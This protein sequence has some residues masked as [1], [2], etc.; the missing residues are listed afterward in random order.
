MVWEAFIE[1]WGYEHG[2]ADRSTCSYWRQWQ[3][4]AYWF[5][6]PR[7][8][9]H[10]HRHSALHFL[11]PSFVTVMSFPIPETKGVKKND[12]SFKIITHSNVHTSDINQSKFKHAFKTEQCFS[13]FLKNK[14]KKSITKNTGQNWDEDTGNGFFFL[15]LHF[16]IMLW[17]YV[18]GGWPESSLQTG[19][20]SHRRNS[21]FCLSSAS[22]L[23]AQL[24]AGH[25]TSG[26]SQRILPADTQLIL[27]EGN[28]PCLGF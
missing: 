13:F 17:I 6:G 8:N 23:P 20:W 26:G 14:E 22:R 7:P 1:K 21:E 28:H 18:Q 2:T 16:G 24:P 25:P 27:T 12:Q 19:L 15:K 4:P 3:T 9:Y 10:V 5:L 11:L